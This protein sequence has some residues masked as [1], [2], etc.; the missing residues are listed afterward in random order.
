MSFF[1]FWNNLAIDIL[2]Y[3]AITTYFLNINLIKLENCHCTNFIVYDHWHENTLNFV[4]IHVCIH[5]LNH[6]KL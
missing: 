3:L 2:F 1:S 4:Y 5:V 6:C